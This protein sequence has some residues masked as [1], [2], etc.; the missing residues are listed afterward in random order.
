LVQV[1]LRHPVPD[2][3]KPNILKETRLYFH[4]LHLLAAVVGEDMGLLIQLVKMGV[5]AVAVAQVLL[6]M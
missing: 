5:V 4:P 3:T 2:T 1:V 6:V